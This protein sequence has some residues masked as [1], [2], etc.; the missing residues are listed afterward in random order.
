MLYHNNIVKYI[1]TQ[2]IYFIAKLD[3]FLFNV[4]RYLVQSMNDCN[5]TYHY[6]INLSWISFLRG[7]ILGSS[8][9]LGKHII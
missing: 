5:C 8:K 7:C 3:D 6:N 4:S 9:I 2:F 1:I